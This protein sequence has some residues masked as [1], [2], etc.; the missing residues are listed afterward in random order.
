[1]FGDFCA[2]AHAYS[3]QKEAAGRALT[4]EPPVGATGAGLPTAALT[5]VWS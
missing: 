2:S 4:L 5:G 3:G 1:M